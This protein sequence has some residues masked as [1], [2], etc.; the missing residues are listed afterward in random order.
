MITDLLAT[1][2]ARGLTHRLGLW[3]AHLF[4]GAYCAILLGGFLVQF[5]RGEFPCPL[6]ILQRM[7]MMLTCLGP[8]WIVTRARRGAVSLSDYATGYGVSIIAALAGAAISARQIALHLVPP[9]PGYGEPVLGLHLYTWAFITFCIVLIFCG[10]SLVF[11]R[12]LAPAAVRWR[13]PSAILIGVF[14]ALIVANLGVVFVEEGFHWFLPDN[15]TR[16]ELCH[17]LGICGD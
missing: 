8:L 3:G 17:D 12:E 4:L 15:P 10:V 14:L 7:A 2:R 16:Y 6:C 5:G 9:D 13:I 11:A 1:A